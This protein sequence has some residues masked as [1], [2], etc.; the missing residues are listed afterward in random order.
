MEEEVRSALGHEFERPAAVAPPI[1]DSSPSTLPGS[2]SA[3]DKTPPSPTPTGLLPR[4]VLLNV[5]EACNDNRLPRPDDRLIARIIQTFTNNDAQLMALLKSFTYHQLYLAREISADGSTLGTHFQEWEVLYGDRGERVFREIACTPDTLKTAHV[6]EGTSKKMEHLQP[7]AFPPE[8]SA[9]H[10]FQYVDHVALDQIHA[11]KFQVTPRNLEKGKFRFS[12]FIWVEDRSLQIV[13]A[14]GN[15]AP[16]IERGM[17]TWTIFPHF[18]TFRSQLSGG[19]WFPTLAVGE[20]TINGVRI[21]SL[22]KYFGYQRF[23][24]ESHLTPIIDEK[25]EGN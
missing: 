12:G 20:S 18:V 19:L 9:N 13:K 14:E 25:K 11:Y 2:V 23:Q 15:E 8:N 7:L 4:N 22:S 16:G 17:F 10:V 21:H 3:T 24:A 1:L 5:G 6:L